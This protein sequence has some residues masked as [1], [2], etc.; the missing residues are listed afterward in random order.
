M[1]KDNYL[2]KD[3]FLSLKNLPKSNDVIITKPNKGNGIVL[4]SKQDRMMDIISDTSKFNLIQR[5]IFSVLL[6]CEVKDS[7]T[8]AKE[9]TISTSATGETGQGFS[10]ENLRKMLEVS[11]KDC[12]FVFNNQLYMQRDGVGMGSPLGP[13]LANAFSCH[14]D[15]IW[16]SNSPIHFKPLYYKRFVKICNK[17]NAQLSH[18]LLR[19]ASIQLK[20]KVSKLVNEFYPQVKLSYIQNKEHYSKSFQIQRYSTH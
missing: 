12:H 6:Q 7:L 19:R 3:E 17:E 5:D 4:L 20:L 18:H 13:T 15:H 1:S 10:K 14:Y 9:I 8:F 2:P 11:V 16:L